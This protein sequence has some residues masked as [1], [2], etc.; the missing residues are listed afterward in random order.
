MRWRYLPAKTVKSLKSVSILTHLTQRKPT[1][2]DVG[3][4]VSEKWRE[5]HGVDSL[6]T[7]SQVIN[8]KIFK[9]MRSF[10]VQ[11]KITKTIIINADD[12]SGAVDAVQRLYADDTS[13]KLNDFKI[14]L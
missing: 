6:F 13:V 9:I 7:H 3:C 2:Q 4:I 11:V 14:T 10:K 5:Y 1:H 8:I 12:V